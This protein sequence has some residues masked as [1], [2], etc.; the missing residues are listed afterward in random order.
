[1]PASYAHVP[2]SRA[3]RYLTQLCSH[4]RLMSRLA[5]HRAPG[6][7]QGHDDG[8]GDGHGNGG[9]P[10]VATASSAGAE[11]IIDFGW[12]R[13]TL[14]ATVGAL[15]LYAEAEDPRRLRQIEDGISARLQRIGRRD[16]LAVTWTGAGVENG[17]TR[18]VDRGPVAPPPSPPPT[19][20]TTP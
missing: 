6:R 7:G 15:T 2:T 18:H 1:M 14:R 11:G 20:P 5:R 16:Q 4:G 12:G 8:G 19:R 3:A 13:C 17:T 10:P 9:A